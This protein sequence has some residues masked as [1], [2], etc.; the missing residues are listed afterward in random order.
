[1][2]SFGKYR[3]LSVAR[4]DRRISADGPEIKRLHTEDFCQASGLPP[5]KKYESDGGP[6]ILS[7][8][9]FLDKSADAEGDKTAFLAFQIFLWL[10]ES[11][12]GHAKN[13]S[14]FLEPEGKVRLAPFYD[15]LSVAPLVKSGALSAKKI[16][17]AMA[18]SGKSRHYKISEIMPRHFIETAV[19]CG[20]REKVMTDIF[21]R[22][23]N[24]GDALETGFES[25]LP[26]G[27][28]ADVAGPVLES[29]RKKLRLIK[30]Y[31]SA[32][33]R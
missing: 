17:L 2:L 7:V 10:I 27:F 5:S 22:F 20:V 3:V 15:V 23:V 33:G 13:Y 1:V 4:F 32:V 24:L 29:V 12:D 21:V 19:K 11:T 8:C 14:V 16:R 31:L 28:P 25:T 6:G 26:N 18:L 30:A 9:S